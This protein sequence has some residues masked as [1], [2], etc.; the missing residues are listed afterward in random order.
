MVVQALDFVSRN[1][2]DVRN[3]YRTKR[4]SQ[5]RSEAHLKVWAACDGT[6]AP[7]AGISL[8]NS[9]EFHCSASPPRGVG[10]TVVGEPTGGGGMLARL[11]ETHPP[12]RLQLPH[13]NA[14]M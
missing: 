14:S 2:V 3:W 10:D 4:S 6:G 1:D 13:S 5:G 11:A 12:H 8:I 7:Q 9:G